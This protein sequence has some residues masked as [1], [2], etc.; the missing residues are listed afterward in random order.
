MNPKT[1]V[2]KHAQ[3]PNNSYQLLCEVERKCK[4]LRRNGYDYTI[5]KKALDILNKVLEL[6]EGF[7][8]KK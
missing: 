6:E 1:E 4:T 7:H 8:A 2:N 3:N 5:I